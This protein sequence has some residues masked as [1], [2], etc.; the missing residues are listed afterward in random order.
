VNIAIDKLGRE[1]KSAAKN[2]DSL[3]GPAPEGGGLGLGGTIDLL[4]GALP[5]SRP[6]GPAPAAASPPSDFKFGD[7][8]KV[9]PTPPPVG[10]AGGPPPRPATAPPVPTAP[11]PTPPRGV[12]A[13]PSKPMAATPSG[14]TSFGLDD[15]ILG[16]GD[17]STPPTSAASDAAVDPYFKQVFDQFV[18][19]KQSCNES[20]AG[21]TIQK[22]SEKL[23]KNRD[24]LRAKTGCKDVKFTVYV[25][26]G[27]A[28]LK[29]TPVKDE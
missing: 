29:A 17:P 24:D 13:A 20:T 26:D 5:P 16:G 3:L 8:G 21:L 11:P 22:F 7:P 23:I 4:A 6:G 18:A 19:V 27:K 2:L 14:A 15:D 12:P 25:K 1:A 9:I 28:A 10:R